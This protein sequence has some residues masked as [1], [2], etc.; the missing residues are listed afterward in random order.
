MP[1]HARHSTKALHGLSQWWGG[2]YA[3]FIGEQV[4]AQRYGEIQGVQG[5]WPFS[6][7]HPFSGCDWQETSR[8]AYG[9]LRWKI[10]SGL[11]SHTE[12][13]TG[14]VFSGV[15]KHVW[16]VLAV[17]WCIGF[18]PYTADF[19]LGTQYACFHLSQ[20]RRVWKATGLALRD[21]CKIPKSWNSLSRGGVGFYCA[22]H[23]LLLTES[24]QGISQA[25]PWFY[26]WGNQDPKRWSNYRRLWSWTVADTEPGPR[27]SNSRL[28]LLTPPISVYLFS[29]LFH[30][31]VF[32]PCFRFPRLYCFFPWLH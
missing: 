26:G 32:L 30:L 11:G 31:R 17:V 22:D 21:P 23:R 12:E 3:H 15:W 13:L 4:E 6:D 28:S 5:V 7:T 10:T 14:Q 27:L 9:H 1:P 18:S 29:Y 2:R 16:R 8:M 24:S 25:F 20:K 19:Q